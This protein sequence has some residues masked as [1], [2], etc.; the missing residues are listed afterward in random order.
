MHQLRQVVQHKMNQETHELQDYEDPV[1]LGVSDLIIDL[2]HMKYQK[3][4]FNFTLNGV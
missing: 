1:R 2:F 3:T 4:W